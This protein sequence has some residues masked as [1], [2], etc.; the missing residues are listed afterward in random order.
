MKTLG[1]A[2]SVR[3]MAEVALAVLE[4]ESEICPG[5][6]RRTEDPR[7]AQEMQP[8]LHP[9]KRGCGLGFSALLGPELSQWVLSSVD[10][11]LQATV[12]RE[13][14]NRT[15]GTQLGPA[16]GGGSSSS[17]VCYK[18]TCTRVHRSKDYLGC[19]VAGPERVIFE[20]GSP[21]GLELATQA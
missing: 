12:P 18:S 19:H 21:L 13:S 9:P 16:S 5:K 20:T 15:L 2:L 1:L 7:G 4:T 11:L 10:S 6:A 17:C 8:C 14:S 3:Q